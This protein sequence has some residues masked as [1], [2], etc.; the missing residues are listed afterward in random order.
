MIMFGIYVHVPFCLR[1]CDYCDFY[2]V[3]FSREEAPHG[4]YLKALLAQLD[5]DAPELGLSGRE[6]ASIYFGGGTPS[7]MPP[8][9]FSKLIEALARHFSFSAELEVSCEVNP[10][11]ADAAWF[12]AARDAGIT[13]CSIGVQSFQDR[14]LRDLGRIHAADEA[15]RAIAEAQDAGFTGISMDLM[16]AIP[17]ETMQELEEDV[18]TAM[19][20]QP[21]HISAY[22]LTIEEG[23]PLSE[24]YAPPLCE[25]R[26]GGVDHDL[27][28]LSPPYKGGEAL[29]ESD[30][31]NQM[32]TVDRMLSRGGW[33][34]YE[35]SNF[36]KPG[37]ECRHN[38]N[39]WRYGEYLGL[40]A[41]AASF[42][43]TGLGIRDSGFGINGTSPSGFPRG[44]GFP[45]P[46]SRVPSPVFARRFTQARNVHAYM[47]GNATLAES[48]DID[49]RTAMAEYC[50]L[51][52]R[53]MEG[54]S[55]SSFKHEFGVE[56]HSIFGAEIEC[57]VKRRLAVVSGDRMALT[58]KGVEISNQVFEKF[59][60]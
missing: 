10:A 2:S 45:N 37:C 19:T 55:A 40:G 54:I 32:R 57:L 12:R 50:F 22:Q 6:I 7:I 44:D 28:P 53:T 21:D 23:T 43:T 11:T 1:K 59:F 47:E 3:P 35:I 38:L 4:P 51:G 18:R 20:F 30:Q 52:L 42:V 26:M 8:E 9:F 39:Y 31:L 41:G 34:R 60:A 24:Q 48:E 49:V 46:G 17:S 25:G 16:Y 14:L 5:R 15:M 33:Q 29:S 36:A 27:P 56:L 13:R 58:Q